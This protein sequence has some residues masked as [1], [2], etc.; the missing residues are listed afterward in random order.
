VA[1]VFQSGVLA[2]AL[3]GCLAFIVSLPQIGSGTVYFW[4][5]NL[6]ATS[7]FIAWLGIAFSHIQFR[8]AYKEQ[9]RAISELPYIARLYPLGPVYTLLFGG[10]ILIGQGYQSFYPTF[11]L[12]SFCASYLTIPVFILMYVGYKVIMRTSIRPLSLVDLDT[13]SLKYEG[14]QSVSEKNFLRRIWDAI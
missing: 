9:R 2:T 4:L 13:G 7:G 14:S 5:L 6:S 11:D 8:R 1:A 12:K 3:V 10:F